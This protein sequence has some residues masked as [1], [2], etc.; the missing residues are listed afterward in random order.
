VRIESGSVS[1]HGIYVLKVLA[2]WTILHQ[3]CPWDA[4]KSKVTNRSCFL[5]PSRDAIKL[6]APACKYHLL[7]W[8]CGVCKAV[9]G[10]CNV[11]GLRQGTMVLNVSKQQRKMRCVPRRLPSA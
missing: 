8:M 1:I 9:R 3:C 5:A 6:I 7:L 4:L 2:M 10:G 11:F